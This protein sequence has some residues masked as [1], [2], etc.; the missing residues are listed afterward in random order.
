MNVR[1]DKTRRWQHQV[2]IN[3]RY[4]I[5]FKAC[6]SHAKMIQIT[7]SKMIQKRSPFKIPTKGYDQQVTYCLK[8][9]DRLCYL[10]KA[11]TESPWNK[12]PNKFHIFVVGQ[13]FDNDHKT[14]D[15][16]ATKP[17]TGDEGYPLS[18]PFFKCLPIS[19]SMPNI[20]S[21]F[22]SYPCSFTLANYPSPLSYPFYWS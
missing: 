2:D 1:D 19:F 8:K 18:G 15:K 9:N 14:N 20:I 17:M 10:K 21:H 13:H 16:A 12:N 22:W 3:K 7:P 4:D 6:Q 11:T 5:E